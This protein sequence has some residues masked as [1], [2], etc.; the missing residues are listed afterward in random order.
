[1]PSIVEYT[2]IALPGK[3]D[4]LIDSSI[5]LADRFGE[6]NVTIRTVR[7]VGYQLAHGPQ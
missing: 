2:M 7:G 4:E 3:Y 1:M 5:E 6:V